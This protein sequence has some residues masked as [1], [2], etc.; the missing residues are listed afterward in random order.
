MQIG[1]FTFGDVGTHPVTKA[2][3]GE[4]Q[5]MRNLMEEIKLADEVGLDVFAVG[6]HHRP[7]Y[8]ISSIAP[9]LGAAAVLTKN[10]RLAS[11]VTVLS[12]EDPVRVFQQFATIDLLSN[13]R[14][15]IIAGRGSFIESF[16]L[17]GYDLQ[18]YDELFTEKLQM[19]LELNKTEVLHWKGRHT[20]TVNGRGVYPRPVQK[21]LPIWIGVGGT[22]ESVVRAAEL[23]LPLAIAIIG[24]QPARFAPFARLYKDVYQKAG[25][26]AAQLQLGINSFTFIADSD[27]KARDL[28]WPTYHEVTSRIGRERGWSPGTRAQF[29]A[30]CDPTGALLVGSP[31]TVTEK[32]LYEHKLFGHTRFMAQVGLGAMPHEQIMHAINL[33]GT[34]VAPAVRRALQQQSVAAVH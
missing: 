34:E 2:T 27:Q 9:V 14:A 8:L 7:D 21:V 10:I 24:G 17:F 16:P 25:H 3:I 12:S 32:I 23:G 26:N 5:R 1:V 30:E 15:E 11:A 22:P 31:Q 13:G 19:L 28:F 4:Q 18:H 6:E 33:L 20:Q 29:E